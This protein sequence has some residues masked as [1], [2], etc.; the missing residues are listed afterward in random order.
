MLDRLER[1]DRTTELHAVLRVLHRLLEHVLRPAH[2]LVAQTD[3]SLIEGLGQC[4][5]TRAGRAEQLA[6]HAVELE[7]GLLA[8]LIHRGQRRAG[9]SRRVAV[10]GVEGDAVGAA[11]SRRARGNHDQVRDMT[12]EHEHLRAGQRGAITRRC[13]LERDARRVPLAVWLGE[14]QSRDGLT[15]RDAGQQRRLLVLR[16]GVEDRVGPKY[17][18]REVRRAQERPTLLL[19]H[20]AEL[21]PAEALA[22]IRL[23]DVQA[24][25][26]ELVRHL[27]P[28]RGVVPLG[29]LHQAPH[30]G[31]GALGLQE[32]P[33]GVA[34]LVLLF[35]KGEVQGVSFLSGAHAGDRAPAHQ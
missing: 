14:R 4:V 2:H 32:F 26:P 21:D 19:E 20:D 3:R 31:L 34:Q 8:R 1:A 9:E 27:R 7:L 15:A 6:L 29:G 18:R 35:G 28:D 25:E 12:V 5:P 23:G 24:L 10:D 22:A 11:R 16:A 17:H 33:N 13:G 30:F